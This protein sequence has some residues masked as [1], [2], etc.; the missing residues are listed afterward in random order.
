MI[1]Y[2]IFSNFNENI[3]DWNRSFGKSQRFVKI[4][5]GFINNPEGHVSLI[6][7]YFQGSSLCEIIENVGS[8]NEAA[9]CRIAIQII[10]AL[11]EFNEKKMEDYGEFCLCDVVFDKEGNLKVK[12]TILN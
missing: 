8:L 3:N 2:K 11:S 9:L 10:Q 7:E 6:L 1:N 4:I 12:I 5:N